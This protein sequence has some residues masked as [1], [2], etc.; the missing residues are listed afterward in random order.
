MSVTEASLSTLALS[1]V[2]ISAFLHASWNLL[3]K[4]QAPTMAFFALAMA[5]GAVFFS[6]V[7]FLYSHWTEL[8]M[9]FWSLLLVWF[10]ISKDH[11]ERKQR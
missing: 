6:P 8:P 7:L 4:K 11:I 1:L 10:T 3:G 2:L 9:H 5:A